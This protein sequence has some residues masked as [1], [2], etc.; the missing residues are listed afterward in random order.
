[1]IRLHLSPMSLSRW[2]RRYMVPSTFTCVCVWLAGCLR[3][4]DTQGVDA[5]PGV[6]IPAA[7]VEDADPMRS[8]GDT[9]FDVHGK[10][11]SIPFGVRP[12]SPY[13]P[14]VARLQPPSGLV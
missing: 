10:S 8:R 3:A 9:A 13:S 5:I 12:P 6:N 11:I 2:L 7:P 14:T 1:M 4:A